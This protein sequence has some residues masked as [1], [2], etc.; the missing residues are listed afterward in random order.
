MSLSFPISENNG[1]YIEMTTPPTT[2]PRNT[3]ITGSNAANRSFTAASTSSSSQSAIFCNIASMAPVCSPTAIICVT[4]PGN[5]CESFS[6][7]VSDLPSSS[8]LRTL[9][10]ACSTTALPAVFAVISKPSRIGTPL[11]IKV[12]SVRVNRATAIFL[13]KMPNT[14]SF[15]MIES[16]TSLPPGVPYQ[17][18]KP[19]MTPPS[20]SRN[21]KPNQLPI[22]LLKPI[23]IRVGNGSETP[24]PANNVA[25]I[26]T[27]FHNSKMMTPPATVN[28]PTGYTIAA[29]T[30][31]CNFTFFSM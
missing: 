8:D 19:K 15:N 10:N 22:K 27:T 31:R 12:P 16:S 28:T 4:M 11:E 5:T 25:K 20:A 17:V 23:T 30:A 14:G 2:T 29:F 13:I 6:G 1:K 26:G 3:I 9:I 24:K 21:M 18:F 7:S